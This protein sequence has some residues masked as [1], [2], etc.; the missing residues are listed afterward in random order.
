MRARAHKALVIFYNEAGHRFYS[1]F[2][3]ASSSSVM[4]ADGGKDAAEPLISQCMRCKAICCASNVLVRP[5]AKSALG[6]SVTLSL[7]GISTSSA[8]RNLTETNP[9]QSLLRPES[10]H[11][12][13]VQSWTICPNG[14]NMSIAH[15]IAHSI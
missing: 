11:P 7:A 5:G 9:A 6:K 15:N 14:K 8:S 12:C 2:K 13:T 3:A 1:N 10:G 4:R